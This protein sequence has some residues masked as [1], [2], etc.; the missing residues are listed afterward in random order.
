M[1]DI[2]EAAVK[3][4]SCD[5]VLISGSAHF[6]LRRYAEGNVRRVLAPSIA[7]AMLGFTAGLAYRYLAD[8]PSEGSAA[9][10][11][12]SGLH[13]TGLAL[14]GWAV[15]LYLISRSSEWLR[16]SP[17]LLEIA[18]RAVVMAIVISTVGVSLQV[19]LYGYRLEA[20]WLIG[21]FPRIVATAFILSVLFSAVFEL[22]RLIGGP[23]LINIILGRY[24]RP[25]REERIFMFLDLVGSTSLAETMGELRVHD[26]LARFFFDIDEAIVA[27]GGEVHAYVGDEVIVTWPL[28]AEMS[29]ERCLD[30]FFAVRD[31]IAEKA[32]SYRQE[33]GSIPNFRAGLHAGPV[34]ISECGNSRRQIAY[35]GDTVNVTARL[36]EVCKEVGL[37]LLVSADL[38]RYVRP[39]SDFV[40]KPL[41]E[42][43]LRGRSATVEVFAVERGTGA[44]PS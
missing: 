40:V 1:V 41:G 13:G 3:S 19:M 21:G 17:L 32:D 20:A 33:F 42:A 26:L 2:T 43:Q 12:R 25:A 23:A 5:F 8:D 37:S 22:T 4:R 10:Y 28:D 16:R 18:L 7:A 11:V 14:S 35:F 38:L 30:C 31:R 34:V 24:R 27:H 39:G 6:A 29:G 9:N 15:H 44:T 36:Q